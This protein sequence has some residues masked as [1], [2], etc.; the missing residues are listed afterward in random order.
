MIGCSGHLF[1]VASD[2]TATD[3]GVMTV[4]VI[5]R[6]RG[7]IA[8]GTAVT[9]YRPTAQFILPAMS[10]GAMQVPGYTQG[11]ALDLLEV[12]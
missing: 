5:N 2:C 10:A 9:W 7:T 1:Q 3:A 4:P 11:P 8:S 12:Y 6:V